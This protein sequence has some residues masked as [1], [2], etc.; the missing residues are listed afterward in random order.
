MV[1]TVGARIW[2]YSLLSGTH[3]TG[4]P[5]PVSCYSLFN[6]PS[7]I[8]SI[9]TRATSSDVSATDVGHQNLNVTSQ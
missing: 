1:D 4:G 8:V 5:A 6:K 2:R 3:C 9:L 7:S